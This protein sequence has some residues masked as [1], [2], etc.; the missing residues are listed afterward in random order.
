MAVI[1]F[2]DFEIFSVTGNLKMITLIEWFNREVH[3]KFCLM[4]IYTFIL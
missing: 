1:V 2:D 3:A 4:L